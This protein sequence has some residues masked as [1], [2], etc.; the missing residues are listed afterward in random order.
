M[1]NIKVGA[2]SPELRQLKNSF[3]AREI[4]KANEDVKQPQRDRVLDF[5]MPYLENLRS[6]P[7]CFCLPG[8]RWSFETDL[9]RRLEYRAHFIGVERNYT[10]LEA[11]LPWMPGKGRWHDTEVT[12]NKRYRSFSSNRSYVFWC[13]L[14]DFMSA[15]K[16]NAMTK[17]AQQRWSRLHK[18]WSC[19]WLDLQCQI[20]DE[21]VNCCKLLEPHLDRSMPRIPVAITF[22]VGREQPDHMRWIKA[23]SRGQGPLDDRVQYLRVLLGGDNRH[24]V[25]E[26]ADAWSYATA[27]GGHMGV[28]TFLMVNK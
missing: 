13:S 28:A 7:R 10:V 23:F 9:D 25:A 15:S 8:I 6:V 4:G 24:R 14:R 3:I 5:F 2:R 27:T 26:V 19:A 21:T 20:C 16:N 18:R 11:G 1:I 12:K 22:Q 17:S